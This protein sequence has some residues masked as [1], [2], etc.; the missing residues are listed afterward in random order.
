MMKNYY[1]ELPIIPYQ[2]TTVQMTVVID[3]LK[4][5]E[6]PAEIKRATYVIFR[7]ESANGSKGINNNYIGFQSDSGRWQA[8]YD[9]YLA[10]VCIK[11]E[12][13]TG[14]ERGFL[15]FKSWENSIDILCDKLK[16]RGIYIGGKTNKITSISVD[17]INLLAVAYLREWVT[18][19]STYNPNENELNNFY[20]M[21]HQAEKLFL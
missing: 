7:N 2:K 9:Q 10:G 4:S 13:K 11:T 20:S 21:Y 5:L 15:C 1:P 17:N 3:Y 19:L 16:D 14:K 12:N 6:I 8:K 18:G